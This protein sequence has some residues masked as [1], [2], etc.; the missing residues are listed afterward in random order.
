MK[1]K[2]INKLLL[3]A[4]RVDFANIISKSFTAPNSMNVDASAH[5][6]HWTSQ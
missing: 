4:Q 1:V 5:L 2:M 6:S 3:S